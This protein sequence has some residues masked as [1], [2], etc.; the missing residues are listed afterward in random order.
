MKKLLIWA[1]NIL[2]STRL[3]LAPLVLILAARKDWGPACAA[4]AAGLTDVLDGPLA[5]AGGGG[6]RAGA[7]LDLAA[8]FNLIFPLSLL[9]A[10]KGAISPV[11]PVLTVL[12]HLAYLAN[13][14]AR[15]TMARHRFGRYTGAVCAACLGAILLLHR[16]GG[17][18]CT[19]FAAVQLLMAACLLG[20]LAEGLGKLL[21]QFAR[22]L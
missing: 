10:A 22:T 11:L 3:L 5:R 18:C 4:L 7:V 16:V 13:C 21:P 1:A 15:G 2:L 12:S 8:D 20:A 17:G 6:S 14:A 9:L 19:S